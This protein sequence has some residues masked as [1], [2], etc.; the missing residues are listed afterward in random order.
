MSE[1]GHGRSGAWRFFSW[2]NGWR[3]WRAILLTDYL[4]RLLYSLQWTCCCLAKG[5]P[6]R[7]QY[8]RRVC[9]KRWTGGG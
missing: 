4:G 9:W 6:Q 3:L 7:L 5:R 8:E 1:N 2:L